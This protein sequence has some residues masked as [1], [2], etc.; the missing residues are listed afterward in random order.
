MKLKT[1]SPPDLP[2]A[3]A[4]VREAL[5]DDAIFLST[6]PDKGKRSVTI[7]AALDGR[8]DPAVPAK[9]APPSEPVR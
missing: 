9:P 6:Q 1:F 5:G 2:P 8:E 7:T 3:M 4:M